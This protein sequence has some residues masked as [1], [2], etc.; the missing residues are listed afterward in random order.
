MS[1]A[2]VAPGDPWGPAGTWQGQQGEEWVMQWAGLGVG[3]GRKN[4]LQS[5]LC[6]VAAGVEG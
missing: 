6:K 5:D 4:H 1:W 3:V 2:V